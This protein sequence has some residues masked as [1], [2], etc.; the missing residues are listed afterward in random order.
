MLESVCDA[1]FLAVRKGDTAE[2]DEA[3]TELL[4]SRIMLAFTY[5]LPDALGDTCWLIAEVIEAQKDAV[6]EHV[7]EA[8]L[9]YDAETEAL[10]DDDAESEYAENWLGVRDADWVNECV[11]DCVPVILREYE[12]VDVGNMLLLWDTD[13]V[14]VCDRVKSWLEL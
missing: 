5:E 6:T 3:V 12:R 13:C 11:S 9:L 14:K 7:R 10:E 2:L 4:P 8:S 1:D